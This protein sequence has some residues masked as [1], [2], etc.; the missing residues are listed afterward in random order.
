M[1]SNIN[2]Y[3]SNF[4]EEHGSPEM[5]DAWMNTDN[6]NDFEKI[7]A[8]AKI[9]TTS[10]KI[11][12]PNAPKKARSAYLFF[13]EEERK[14]LAST[15]AASNML[16]ELGKNWKALQA[17]TKKKDIQSMENYKKAAEDDKVRYQRQ[18]E[19][20]VPPTEEEMEELKL[21]KSVKDPDAPK[22]PKSAYMFFCAE[23]RAEI[24]SGVE[25]KQV[26]TELGKAWSELKESTKKADIKE[27][28]GFNQMAEADKERYL[29]EMAVY[30]PPNLE[31]LKELQAL[32]LS[33]SP[34][35]PKSPKSTKSPKDPDAPKKPKSAYM[36]FCAEERPNI[37]KS[38]SGKEVMVE[39]GKAW[40][41]LNESKKKAD[42][43]RLAGFKSDA[44][45]DKERYKEEMKKKEEE[46][47]DDV[48]SQATL[49]MDTDD[50]LED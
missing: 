21:L 32:K 38:F 46:K 24:A 41:T 11:K 48:D 2:K 1:L 3:I 20:Y 47:D 37:A 22:K 36:F 17:S 33:K 49:P 8:N 30:M 9:K 43:K 31:K 29:T 27:C 10:P 6:Q 23:K 35:S 28:K 42:Q 14:R 13:C 45:K 16:E 26:M 7:I 25:A 40:K 4:I 12:D 5:L 44:E 18:M 15:V 50:D 39:L 34:K 19:G